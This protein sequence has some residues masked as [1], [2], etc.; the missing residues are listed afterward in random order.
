MSNY[1][2]DRMERRRA[3]ETKRGLLKKIG[4]IVSKSLRL[5]KGRKDAN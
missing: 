3:E 1:W 2:L 5:K 4:K